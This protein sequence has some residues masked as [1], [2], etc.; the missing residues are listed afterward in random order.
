MLITT[1]QNSSMFHIEKQFVD[2]CWSWSRNFLGKRRHVTS[3]QSLLPSVFQTKPLPLCHVTK[4]GHLSRSGFNLP[5]CGIVLVHHDP[6]HPIPWVSNLLPM[7]YAG[8]Q[9]ESGTYMTLLLGVPHV[10]CPGCRLESSKTQASQA[11][12]FLTRSTVY[13]QE[14]HMWYYETI[15][16]SYFWDKK[17]V[18]CNCKNN[19]QFSHFKLKGTGWHYS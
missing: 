11:F 14:V 10:H 6:E 9:H 1:L 2:T 16:I 19:A 3:W 4:S 17:N 13:I 7:V 8:Y 18:L 12:T 5:L 15:I